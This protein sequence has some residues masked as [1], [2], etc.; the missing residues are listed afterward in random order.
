ML[1]HAFEARLRGLAVAGRIV[2]GDGYV[3]RSYVMWPWGPPVVASLVMG[4]T[5]N[6]RCSFRAFRCGFQAFTELV[7]EKFPLPVEVK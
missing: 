2:G 6:R 7:V 5:R 3:I 4:C 1:E